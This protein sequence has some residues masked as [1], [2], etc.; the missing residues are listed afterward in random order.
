MHPPLLPVKTVTAC[1]DNHMAE[2]DQVSASQV[3]W[4]AA[5]REVRLIWLQLPELLTHRHLWVRKAASRLLG[6]AFADSSI[7]E[8]P[9]LACTVFRQSPTPNQLCCSR[10]CCR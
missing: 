8:R 7:G 2:L 4:T 9:T 3:Q 5:R 1:A 10:H 6:L